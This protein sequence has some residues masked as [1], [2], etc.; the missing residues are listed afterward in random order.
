[1][2]QFR[3]CAIHENEAGSIG[4]RSRI[5]EYKAIEE[6]S[7]T[8]V[9]HPVTHVKDGGPSRRENARFTDEPGWRSV[10]GTGLARERGVRLWRY[11]ARK[12]GEPEGSPFL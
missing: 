1:M 3:P 11:G 2:P 8:K 5:T 7:Q 12:K 10:G 4:M 9:R 6:L